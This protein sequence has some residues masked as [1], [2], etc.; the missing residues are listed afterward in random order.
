MRTFLPLSLSNFKTV[1]Y[2]KL[3]L[4]LLALFFCFS[5]DLYA[6]VKPVGRIR[7]A[8]LIP[9][10][11]G[12]IKRSDSKAHNLL[13]LP[14]ISYNTPVNYI[15]NTPITPLTPTSSGVAAAGYSGLAVSFRSGFAHPRGISTDGAGNVFLSD[16]GSSLITEYPTGGGAPFTIGTG[17]QN[18]DGVA[19]DG[20][21][22]VYVSDYGSGKVKKVLAGGGAITTIGTGY[23]A[24]YGVA[25][26][27]AGNVYVADYL[28]G[29][30]R[31]IPANGGATVVIGSGFTS[32][33][34][35]AVDS[36]GNVYVA[37][38]G[39]STIKKIPAAGG[40]PITLGTGFLNPYGVTVDHL[41]NVFVAD[42]GHNA[43]KEIP[44][45]GGAP[46]TIATGFQT[47]TGVAVDNAG[48]VYTADYDNSTVQSF[49]PVGGYYVSPA[50]PAG[51]SIDNSTGVISG[52]PTKL[53]PAAFYTVTAYNSSGSTSFNINISVS[54]LNISYASPQN[55][56]LGTAISPLSPTGAGAVGAAGYS[57]TPVL[58]NTI[59]SS[60]YSVAIDALNNIYVIQSGTF[61][62][63]KYP[64][65]GGSSS[66]MG[67]GFI[68]PVDLT[69]DAAGNIYVA[70][71][72]NNAIKKIPSGNG[73][74]ITL[75]SGFNG[76][77]GVAV[78]AAG[79]VY[80]A[81]TNNNLVKEIPI[82]GGTVLT[83]GSGFS[84]PT[85]VAVDAYG[86]VYVAD[87][88]NGAIKKIPAGNLAPITLVSGLND[89]YGVSVDFSGNVFYTDRNNNVVKELI[90]GSGTPVSIGSGYNLPYKLTTDA[91]GNVYVA[92]F[93]NDAIK[94]IK[95][96][97]GYFIEKALPAGLSFSSA[98]G[99][100]SGAPKAVSAATNYPIIAYNSAGNNLAIVNIKVS[101]GIIA[102]LSG[103]AISPGTLKPAFAVN[104]TNY[105]TNVG[106]GISSIVL[107]PTATDPAATIK[108]NSATVASGSASAAIPL[109]VGSNQISTAVTAQDGATTIIYTLSVTRAASNNAKLLSLTTSSGV[110]SPAFSNTVTSYTRA[111]ANTVTSITV[112]PTTVDP[113]ATIA[114]NGA[115]VASGMASGS[116]ALNVG[117]NLIST[118]VTAQDGTTKITYTITV[119]RAASADASLSN[120]AISPGTL[121]PVFATATTVYNV[122]VG[123]GTTSVIVTPTTTDPNATIK[124]NGITVTSGNASAPI[125]LA[126]GANVVATVITA[127]NGV[128]TKNYKITVT[129]APSTN[130]KLLSL[131]TSSGVLSPAFVNTATSY[132][133]AVPNSV[134][135][136]TFTPTTVDKNA[137]VVVNS[138]LTTS[139]TA[140][141][142]QSLVVGDNVVKVIVTAQDGITAIV[143]TVTVTRAMGSMNNVYEP[144]AVERPT[145][146]PIL[147][148]DGINVHQAVSPNGDGINDFL[149]IE[150][151]TNYPDNKLQIMNRS[152]QLVFEAKGYDN[153]SRVFDGHS[154]KTGTVQLPGTYFYSL[155]YSVNGITKHKTGFI[156]LKY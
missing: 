4:Y 9:T 141:A 102:T 52:T 89:T 139:G 72:S 142:P 7:R 68:N 31:K 109:S 38:F 116:I 137:T 50:L 98:T 34:G 23:N 79:N 144:V 111:V 115:A 138:V 39:A 40:S 32:P 121:K 83:L 75:G 6:V 57:S 103:L 19:V 106:N 145:N 153:T 35:V 59:A 82:G 30:V 10:A 73:T 140:S 14:V 80:V 114:V 146:T 26:D 22:N 101:A 148:D 13:A 126:V 119:T 58:L 5:N 55:Y 93:G 49:T 86:N 16:F 69:I 36:V 105:T 94:Q 54:A 90:G 37:D 113:T 152:G 131:I 43:L 1:A 128:T 151:I 149:I 3:P 74:P 25:A 17:F 154:N 29:V 107:T 99:V 110:L 123:N 97:G 61:T 134:T 65:G 53:S 135:S 20:R 67:S 125:N 120:L 15:V 70:D 130:A 100:I 136:I 150:N 122:A 48:I 143:Y 81:D 44:V 33:A 129:R 117:A 45:G 24:P 76:P 21:E 41:G 8:E 2:C 155:D 27:A 91:I 78:D 96:V 28:N 132:I 66:T 133:R 108:V 87:R 42:F 92:D 77:N 47:L 112:T 95:P 51:L 124:V 104:T 12:V 84:L 64:A 156:V 118:V 71:Y 11:D 56:S 85:S 18:P 60:P 147:N 62:V 63:T 46:I 127:Q 88:S